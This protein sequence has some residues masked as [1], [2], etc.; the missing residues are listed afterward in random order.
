[1]YTHI[2][3]T[4]T[5]HHTKQTKPGRILGIDVRRKNPSNYY[6]HKTPKM[7]PFESISFHLFISAYECGDQSCRRQSQEGSIGSRWFHLLNHLAVSECSFYQSQVY[8]AVW[9]IKGWKTWI[10]GHPVWVRIFSLL[11]PH[12]LALGK[13]IPFFFSRMAIT[14][15]RSLGGLGAWKWGYVWRKH[16]EKGP[17]HRT[18]SITEV[19][20]AL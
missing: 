3:P 11:V 13:L 1:M 10:W 9:G 2:H 4:H 19:S 12:G 15:L 14:A 18:C 7:L 16:L 5:T 8:V 6:F 17:T 20:T